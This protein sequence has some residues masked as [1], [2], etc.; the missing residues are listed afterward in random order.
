MQMTSNFK[1]I[2]TSSIKASALRGDNWEEKQERNRKVGK[3]QRGKL[4][5][6]KRTWEF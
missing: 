5:N 2:K 3:I 6:N 1:A 4:R